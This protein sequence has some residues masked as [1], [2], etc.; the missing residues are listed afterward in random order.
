MNQNALMTQGQFQTLLDMLRRNET[1]LD[2]LTDD[3]N[4]V[5]RDVRT[6]K[7]DVSTLQDDMSHVKRELKHVK[8]DVSMIASVFGFKRNSKGQLFRT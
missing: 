5:K 2:N 1:K 7:D 3:V 6:L 4:E 8:D